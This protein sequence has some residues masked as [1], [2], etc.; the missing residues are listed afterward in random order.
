MHP[1]L[2]NP[3]RSGGIP[4]S[5][6]PGFWIGLALLG[7][8]MG[9]AVIAEKSSSPGWMQLLALAFVSG[10]PLAIALAELRSGYAWKNLAEGGRG[11]ARTN[12]PVRYWSSVL[13]HL[14]L[15]GGINA[16]S[17]WNWLQP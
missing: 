11:V 17:V 15:A 14:L 7:L 8:G 13:F 10:L 12:A 5:N 2:Q 16:F 9:C 4:K 1:Q 6:T 3:I